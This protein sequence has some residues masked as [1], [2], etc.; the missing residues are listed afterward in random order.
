MFPCDRKHPSQR[1]LA[2]PT[3]ASLIFSLLLA[4][5]D[6]VAEPAQL[7]PIA[8]QGDVDAAK[9]SLAPDLYA[10]AGD[11]IIRDDMIKLEVLVFNFGAGASSPTKLTVLINDEPS[12][13][14][15][16][17]F[18]PVVADI[19]ALDAKAD[20]RLFFTAQLAA[21]NPNSDYYILVNL[22]PIP[23]ELSGRGF[24]QDFT[25]FSLDESGRVTVRCQPSGTNNVRLGASDPLTGQQWHLV[26]TGQR[27]YASNGGEPGEDLGMATALRAG[28]EGE[29]IRI[30]I[31][32][33]GLE[34]CHQDL[35]AN[36]EDGASYN[37]NVSH[38]S[39]TIAGDPFQP[40]TLG[41]HGTAVAGVAAAVADNGYGGRGVAPKA[42]LRGYNMLSAV[43]Q[44]AAFLDSL[45][46]SKENPDSTDVDI[47]NM[48]IG[49][50]GD[51][52]H[53]PSD[54]HIA[55]FKN[56][57]DNLRQGRGAIYVK[58]AGNGFNSCSSL[59]R[60]L[61]GQIGCLSANAD[62]LNNLHYLIVVSAFNAA[63]KK[64]SYSSVGSNVWVTAP[65][66]EFGGTNPA[67][68]TTDQMGLNRGYDTLAQRG[69]SQVP[70]DNPNGDHISTFNG[71]S[72]AAPAASGAVALLLGSY[73][74]LTWRD[75]KHILANTA[76]KL[77]ANIPAVQHQVNGE[78]YVSQLP[79]IINAAGYNFHN[80]YGFGALSVDDALQFAASHPS[81]SLG[82]FIE[83]AA[84]SGRTPRSDLNEPGPVGLLR[85]VLDQFFNGIPDYD[86]EGRTKTL[87]VSGLPADASIEAVSL[88]IEVT[89][90]MTNDLGIHLI[91]PSGTESIL[92]PVFNE[93][94]AGNPD[95]DWLLLSNAFYGE[96]PNGQWQLKIVD[97]A[98]QDVGKIDRWSLSFALGTH[99]PS[100]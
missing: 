4:A 75:V 93:V 31:V 68:I 18:E 85:R 40:A 63:G 80:W 70:S 46:A 21:F 60:E 76:R 29:G 5:G 45:G 90:P 81:D 16:L 17:A 42:L 78:T 77:D 51:E 6:G 8:N 14:S 35:A 82:E 71:T 44:L 36:I 88:E 72:S 96:S 1:N 19:P 34:T 89:H 30:A 43:N 47:F 99:P 41:D 50:L 24:N 65:A 11:I 58:S 83:T 92:N 69:L 37:F 62:S 32:D 91:S 39:G 100:N 48:S 64:A 27:A 33:T 86:A 3:L 57:I 38:W 12:W 25:G 23:E 28:P 87:N 66:G 61:N 67:T 95:L 73:P 59:R 2:R 56:G 79:W 53:P 94:L 55:L 98:P 74:N 84:F 26:N 52:A 49:I 54:R 20:L 9:Q 15:T 10:F 22:D 7:P 97:A 13:R